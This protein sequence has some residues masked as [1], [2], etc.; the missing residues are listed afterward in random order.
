MIT[1]EQIRAARGWLGWDR[2]RLSDEAGISLN[3]IVKFENGETESPR[4]KTLHDIEK[5]FVRHGVEFKDG[6]VVPRTDPTT[7]IAG[8][9]WYLRLLEDVHDTL[10]ATK[11]EERDV[12]VLWANE[13][14]SPPEIVQQWKKI[15]TLNPRMRRVVRAGDTF[16]RNPLKEYR[17]MPAEFFYNDVIIVYAD[18]VAICTANNTMALIIKDAPLVKSFKLQAD[19]YFN[20]LE[21]PQESTAHDQT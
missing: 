3:Q 6:G 5:A 9:R 16:L 1:R 19:F 15:R 8:D 4:Q 2:Q 18:K 7:R 13:K 11:E 21:T 20:V 10:A 12:V 14:Q 17:Y